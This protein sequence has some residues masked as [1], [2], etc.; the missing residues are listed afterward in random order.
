MLGLE[1]DNF[2]EKLINKEIQVKNE[3]GVEDK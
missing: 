1:L 2:F 3:R